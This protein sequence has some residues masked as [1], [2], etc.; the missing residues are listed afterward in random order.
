MKDAAYQHRV[1]HTLPFALQELLR[2]NL[3]L[4]PHRSQTDQSQGGSLLLAGEGVFHFASLSE[5]ISLG[6]RLYSL[7]FGN[8]KLQESVCFWAMQQPHTG[9]RKDYWPQLFHDVYET[10]PGKTYQVKLAK[11]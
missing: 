7:L 9:S 2:L 6:K 3:I 11:C 5:R 10:A 8:A 4:F 1:V